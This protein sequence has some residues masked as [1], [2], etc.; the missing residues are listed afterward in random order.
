MAYT[1]TRWRGAVTLAAPL[2][3]L[4]FAAVAEG[5][6][7]MDFAN[8]LTTSQVVWGAIIFVALYLLLSRWALPL[9]GG[10]L[11]IRAEAIAGDLDA[12]RAAQGEAD[13]AVRVLNETTS[14]ARA[15]AQ[16]EINTAVATAKDAAAATATAT[17]TRL[18]AQLAAAEAQIAVTRNA[19][20]GSLRQV[21][22]ETTGALV[23]RL[24]GIAAD[25]SAV[26]SAVGS[27]LAARGQA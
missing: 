12:A 21:A 19:A 5:M 16:T 3:L 6:P 15:A 20:L 14:A 13:T 2:L 9:L 8:P 17:N 26:D 7:Q 10:V 22:T 23:S 27:V 4:P 1:M 11:E 25:Q 24:T 18:D